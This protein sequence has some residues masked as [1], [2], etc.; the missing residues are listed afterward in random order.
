MPDAWPGTSALGRA[1]GA[2]RPSPGSSGACD[3]CDGLRA[4]YLNTPRTDVYDKGALLYRPNRDL[5]RRS[6]N[7]VV[8]EGA[9]DVPAVEAA[10]AQ[11]CLPSRRQPIGS[12]PDGSAP[13]PGRRLGSK[14]SGFLRRRGRCRALGHG[15]VGDRDDP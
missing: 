15:T 12:R 8:V 13:P 1:L 10:A 4:K 6:D 3:V 9:I 7:L 14:A 5:G 2:T 11:A